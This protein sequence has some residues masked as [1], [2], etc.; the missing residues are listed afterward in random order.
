MIQDFGEDQLQD[1]G[2]LVETEAEV[3]KIVVTLQ[4]STLILKDL[5]QL[6][7]D[8]GSRSLFLSDFTGISWREKEG[9]REEG[10]LGV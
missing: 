7:D 2:R 8:S 3:G 9:A 4:H 10:L 5:L 6:L 1:E